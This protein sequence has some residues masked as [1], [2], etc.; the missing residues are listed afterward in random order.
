MPLAPVIPSLG[1]CQGD[2]NVWACTQMEEETHLNFEETHMSAGH[3]IL[4]LHSS[5]RI[6]TGS[7]YFFWDMGKKQSPSNTSWFKSSG[8]QQHNNVTVV[9]FRT[10]K[11]ILH[12]H[13]WPIVN[14]WWFGNS[15]VIY[16]VNILSCFFCLRCKKVVYCFCSVFHI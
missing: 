6:F 16:Q 10:F 14:I 3:F 8:N 9:C 5:V 15:L 12:S 11:G 1:Y 13:L 4:L 2:N 7:V